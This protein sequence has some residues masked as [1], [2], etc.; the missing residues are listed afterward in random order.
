MRS[1]SF[2]SRLTLTAQ[3]MGFLALRFS[4][5]G[6]FSGGLDVARPGRCEFETR[7][8]ELQRFAF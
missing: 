5:A 4:T 6:P 1:I 7:F 8:S 2:F 3:M